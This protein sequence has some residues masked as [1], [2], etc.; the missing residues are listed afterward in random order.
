MGVISSFSV[1]VVIATYNGEKYIL[2]QLNSILPQLNSKDEIVIIDDCSKDN[3]IYVINSLQDNRI[4]LL[5]NSFNIGVK[6]SFERG[7]NQATNELIFLSDQD[8]VWQPYKVEAVKTKFSED[9]DLTLIHS[10]SAV[11]NDKGN[12]ISTSFMDQIGGYHSGLI[13]NFIR[14]TFHGCTMVFRKDILSYCM[15]I[16][17]KAPMHDSWIGLL[18]I[19]FGK[20]MYM[21]DALVLY[22]RHDNNV[23]KSSRENISK[24]IWWRIW[25]FVALFK[26][27]MKILFK[28]N[29]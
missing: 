2:K 1:S 29:F 21:S 19:Y 4:K 20:V 22:R 3:T 27:V 25:L 10:D 15:P 26:R 23:T 12:L 28:V 13:N 11:I 7:L 6:K 14:N 9:K 18:S 5:S 16:P 8:D 17:S 24:V